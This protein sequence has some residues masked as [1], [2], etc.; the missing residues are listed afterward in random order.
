MVFKRKMFED[1]RAVILS[2]KPLWAAQLEER[3]ADLV[4]AFESIIDSF[5]TYLTAYE[6]CSENKKVGMFYLHFTNTTQLPT[7]AIDEC[8]SPFESIECSAG[9]YII[10]ETEKAFASAY[11]AY[12]Q[13]P[14]LLKIVLESDLK[15][16]QSLKK[17]IHE[18]WKAFENLQK[19]TALPAD[20]L[21]FITKLASRFTNIES[22]IRATQ[23][24]SAQLD[25]NWYEELL[26]EASPALLTIPEQQK[27]VLNNSK[28]LQKI[29][30]ILD[31]YTKLS[32]N[33]IIS[34]KD[35][36][37]AIRAAIL[38]HS[39]FSEAAK[40]NA[41]SIINELTQ[42]ANSFSPTLKRILQ[43]EKMNIIELFTEAKGKIAI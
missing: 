29:N 22:L 34:S 35:Q 19:L 8:A 5:E 10:A 12:G 39:I 18:S 24:L 23:I 33:E 4:P 43:K 38:A 3:M 17:F 20:E 31:P 32:L 42:G 36:D 11:K 26:L 25:K 21:D 9:L 15:Q 6:H 40:G 1:A 41:E 28:S 13:N 14:R 30:E 7:N 2:E 37:H 16:N 27:W